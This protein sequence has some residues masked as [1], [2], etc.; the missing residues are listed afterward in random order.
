MLW[1]YLSVCYL[2]I[3]FCGGKVAFSY[4]I[5]PYEYINYI[6]I[7]VDFVKDS[8]TNR[9]L[10]IMFKYKTFIQ[11]MNVFTAIFRQFKGIVYPKKI[12]H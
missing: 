7:F 6:N 11:I 9:T 4:F 5:L 8:L 10:K 2:F 12:Y 1:I 3:Y